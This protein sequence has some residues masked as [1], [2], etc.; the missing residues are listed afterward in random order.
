MRVL[1]DTHVLAWWLLDN[2]RLSPRVRELIIDPANDVMVSTVSA[3]EMATKYRIGK[4]PDIG[5]LVK[6]FETAVRAENFQLLPIGASHA[7]RGGLLDGSHRDPFDRLLA[8]Q[9]L[10]ENI[11]LVTSDPVFKAFGVEVVW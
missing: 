11:P 5:G 2:S 4:W 9:S 10:V 3:F 1:F 8:A 7:L 6:E